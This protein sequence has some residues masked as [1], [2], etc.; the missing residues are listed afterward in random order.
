MK[1]R[2]FLSGI[3]LGTALATFFSAQH[4]NDKI[5][6][7]TTEHVKVVVDLKVKQTK[8]LEEA[9]DYAL[10]ECPELFTNFMALQDENLELN[11]ALLNATIKCEWMIR[12]AVESRAGFA[13]IEEMET[14]INQLDSCTWEWKE[15]E[16]RE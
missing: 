7:F 11:Q 13:T 16:N 2:N 3:L 15:C 6:E 1:F 12:D 14:L 9:W 5:E 10:E 8:Q 4:Y